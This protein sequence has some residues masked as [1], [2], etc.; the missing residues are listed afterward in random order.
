[1]GGLNR[2]IAN[3]SYYETMA[4]R[5][6]HTSD[7]HI[8]LKFTRGY[9]EKVRQGLVDARLETLGRM[10]GLANDENCD[11]FVV[12]GDLFENL[13]VGKA[14]V[15]TAAE[16]LKRFE[17]LV[18]VLPGNHDY[19]QESDDPVWPV[20][21]DALGEGQLV[22]KESRPYDLEPH[23][24]KAIVYPGVCVSRHS[25]QN[26]IGWV[27]SEAEAA[28]GTV[29]IGIAHGS[30]E[31]LSPDFNKDYYPMGKAELEASGMDV[32][33]LGHTHI[34]YP[35]RN[36]VSSDDRCFFPSVPEPDG[37]DCRHPGYAW[38]LEVGED[39]RVTARSHRVGKFRFHHLEETVEGEAG[40]EAL[41]K[42]FAEFD[43]DTSLV[44]LK[45][46]GRLPGEVFERIGDWLDGLEQQALYLESDITELLSEIR[47]QDIDGEFT[48][49][50]FPHRLLSELAADEA[51]TLALQMAHQ[52]MKDAS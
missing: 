32:W 35:D 13:R 39:H 28:G 17:G 16:A 37:F 15:R 22:L 31:G 10:V 18:V 20:F 30:L 4:I 25:A 6:F 12:A 29:R 52:M 40:L 50:S 14:V 36:E 2:Q 8:G 46:K 38:I 5:I 48:Q 23:G 7:V 43:C 27:A 41:Q 45:L 51:D 26:A 1:M 44:K 34:R 47:Q 3:L 19:I 9:S 33:L 21:E 11:L 49:G 42:R 24:V